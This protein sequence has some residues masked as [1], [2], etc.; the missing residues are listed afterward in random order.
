MNC[1][2]CKEPAVVSIK[3][4]FALWHFCEKH[5]T[6]RLDTKLNLFKN[7]YH[8]QDLWDRCWDKA[9]KKGVR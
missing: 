1:V 2:D 9:E 6:K 4:G 5:F 3:D 7:N 8:C